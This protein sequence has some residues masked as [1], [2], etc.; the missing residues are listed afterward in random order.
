MRVDFMTEG[1]LV[2]AAIVIA[3]IFVGAFF[4]CICSRIYT[5]GLGNF[6]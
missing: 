1:C 2:A 4:L 3:A 6:W 5:L